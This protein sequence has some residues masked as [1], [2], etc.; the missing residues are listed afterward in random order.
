MNGTESTVGAVTTS[1]DVK[2]RYAKESLAF[3]C[4]DKN[5]KALFP[6][7][8]KKYEESQKEEGNRGGAG[9]DSNGGLRGS[10]VDGGSRGGLSSQAKYVFIAAAIFIGL[11]GAL[12]WFGGDEGPDFNQIPD[13]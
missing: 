1:D 11:F 2:R 9:A 4:R 8:V 7:L 6:D 10:G 3:N 13:F 12:K 5:F